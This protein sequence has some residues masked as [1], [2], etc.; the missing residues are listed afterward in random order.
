VAAP[1][2]PDPLYQIDYF[3]GQKAASLHLFK[4]VDYPGRMRPEVFVLDGERWVR[5]SGLSPGLAGTPEW[6][7]SARRI[8]RE[9]AQHL[10]QSTGLSSA[11]VEALLTSQEGQRK[12]PRGEGSPIVRAEGSSGPRGGPVRT[13]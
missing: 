12:W 2:D 3:L 11:E 4:K 1:T 7:P 8:T 6:D 13:Y 10:M 5:A 9:E